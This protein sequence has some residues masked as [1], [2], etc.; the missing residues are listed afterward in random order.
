MTHNKA[1]LHTSQ[2]LRRPENADV[3]REEENDR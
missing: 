2:E 3:G 1:L